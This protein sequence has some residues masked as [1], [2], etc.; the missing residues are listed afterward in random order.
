MKKA[1]L[2]AA[3][4]VVA[5]CATQHDPEEARRLCENRGRPEAICDHLANLRIAKGMNKGDI[6]YLYGNPVRINRASYGPDQYIYQQVCMYSRRLYQDTVYIYYEDGKV[7]DWQI[8]GCI[9]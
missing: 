5:G 4:A 1:A 2:I 3:L 6:R 8:S 7:T 9:N